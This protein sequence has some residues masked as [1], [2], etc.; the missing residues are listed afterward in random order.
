[1]NKTKLCHDL[2]QLFKT[3]TIWLIIY[4]LIAFKTTLGMCKYY[5]KEIWKDIKFKEEEK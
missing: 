2:W 3:I 5:V 4:V 1:M